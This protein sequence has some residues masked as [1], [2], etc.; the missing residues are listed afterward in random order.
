MT[1]TRPVP[2]KYVNRVLVLAGGAVVDEGE[3]ADLL[4]RSPYMKLLYDVR[5][6]RADHG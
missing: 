6:D 4:A 2:A 1:S 3:P 5:A